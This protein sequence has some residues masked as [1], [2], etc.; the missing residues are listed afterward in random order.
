[1]KKIV[2]LVLALCMVFALVGSALAED[3]ASGEA[4]YKVLGLDL[5]NKT[6]KTVT[7]WYLYATGAE[8]KG[9]PLFTE[10][11]ADPDEAYEQYAYIVRDAADTYEVYV[12]FEDGTNATKEGIELTGFD[13]IS[14]K[15]AEPGDWKIEPLDDQ[16][17]IDACQAL[18]D[19]GMT[20]DNTYPGYEKIEFVIKNKADSNLKEFYF[21][22]D[23]VDPKTYPN[24][25]PAIRDV[26]NNYDLANIEV[27]EAGK[28]GLYV[29]GF[30]IRPDSQFYTALAVTESGEE[31]EGSETNFT[32]TYKTQEALYNQLSMKGNDPDG[33]KWATIEEGDEDIQTIANAC[34][35]G[36]TLDGW[37]PTYK[38][39]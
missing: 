2:S 30:F 8:D 16:G 37:Y 5:K 15:A 31:L 22:E 24:M 23:G 29:Y 34:A 10:W 28:G 36:Y 17:D 27:W 25:V 33:W 20:T 38:A 19:A 26:A 35:K 14:M 18:I 12:E 6:G 32:E 7:G 39:E 1:M 13:K 11:K 4:T 3:P 21:A 9:D